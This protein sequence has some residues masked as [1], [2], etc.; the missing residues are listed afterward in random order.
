MAQD[1][2]E[3]END[4]DN[5]SMNEMAATPVSQ[6]RA[7]R[8][9]DRLRERMRA[10][11]EKRGA[12]AGKTGEYL[13]LV[14]DIFILLWRLVNDPRVS[15][16]NKVMLGSGLAYYLFPLD[17]MPDVTAIGY[18]DDLIFGVLLLSSVL[19]DTDES[20]LREHWS[21]KEDLL[22]SIQNV[23]DAAENLIGKD[24]IGRLKKTMKF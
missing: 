13:L 6:D 10:Y 17:L 8:F 21:G 18:L 19:K 11:L 16:K 24:V 7:Q 5:E 1:D 9:Y 4:I 22:T 12:L 2:D 20:I 23:M 14:P 3:L 15:S